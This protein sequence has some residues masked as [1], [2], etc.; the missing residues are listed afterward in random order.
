MKNIF[1]ESRGAGSS[2]DEIS[3]T[4]LVLGHRKLKE[5]VYN[6][7]KEIVGV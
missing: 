3:V 4:G 7:G 5:K 2:S 1:I 6:H